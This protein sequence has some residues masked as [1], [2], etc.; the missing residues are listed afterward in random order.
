VVLG[1]G[2]GSGPRLRTKDPNI[3]EPEP[4][5]DPN[6]NEKIYLKKWNENKISI[7]NEINKSIK[8][9]INNSIKMK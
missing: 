2:L 8:N 5:W 3:F 9:E 6:L 1:L 7:K 4:K